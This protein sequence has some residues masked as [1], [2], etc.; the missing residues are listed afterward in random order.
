MYYDPKQ[1]RL[2]HEQEHISNVGSSSSSSSNGHHHHHLHQHHHSSSQLQANA[3]A[4]NLITSNGISFDFGS[5]GPSLVEPIN[6]QLVVGTNNI[7]LL[8]HLSESKRNSRTNY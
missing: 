5:Q 6:Y 8:N 4:Y 2:L 3:P 1:N 7:N